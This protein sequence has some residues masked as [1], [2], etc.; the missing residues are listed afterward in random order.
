VTITRRHH[1][2]LGQQLDVWRVNKSILVLT[3]HDGSRVKL[4]REWTDLDG[5]VPDCALDGDSRFTVSGLRE[6]IHL[7]EQLRNRI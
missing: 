3:L 6:L 5:S 4:P 1:P 2:L 7:V